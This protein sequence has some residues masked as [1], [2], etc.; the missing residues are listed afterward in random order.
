MTMSLDRD[1]RPASA[2]PTADDRAA[3]ADPPRVAN[4]RPYRRLAYH[5][6]ANPAG[7]MLILSMALH[8]VAA[9]AQTADPIKESA[10]TEELSLGETAPREKVAAS[11]EPIIKISGEIGLTNFDY[12]QYFHTP[13]DS[14]D[15]AIG[16]NLIA[17]TA[18][19]AGFSAGAGVYVGQTLGLQDRSSPSYNPELASPDGNRTSLRQAYV[20]YQ[21]G[22]LLVRAGRQLVQTP[23][24]TQDYFTFHPRAFSG[25]AARYD[26]LG[27]T[28]KGVEVGAMSLDTSPARL[29]VMAIRMYDFAGRFVDGFTSGSEVSGGRPTRGFAA[30]G[31]RYNG[32]IG[33]TKLVAQSWYYDFIDYARLAYGHVAV[34]APIATDREFVAAVQAFRQWN[35]SG[36]GR[37]LADA[38][39]GVVRSVDAQIYGASAGSRVGNV[40]VSAIGNYAPAAPGAFRNGGAL[41][42]YTMI[43]YTLFSDTL[44]TGVA[45]LGPGYGYGI[46][47]TLKAFKGKF[48][49]SLSAVR[50]KARY[51]FGKDV[52]T[53]RGPL[54]FG[55]LEATPNQHSWALDAI[56]I[57]DM[58]NIAKGLSSSY[59][60]G[61][62][63]TDNG[64]TLR[65]YDNPF[66][67]SRFYLKW[68]F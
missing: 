65:R 11:A 10:R 51:G 3:P 29:S 13:Q 60:L 43:P 37:S 39:D 50:Y 19:L 15:L 2:L 34:R 31:M 4:A 21:S 59:V 17:H 63:H 61:I 27:D 55:G 57:L 38:T 6:L 41:Q 16:G 42:P 40:T 9:A 45:E 30:L 35:S 64:T 47:V 44:Q 5:R 14:H 66:V 48:S 24:A 33:T 26:L 32:G 12:R 23:F 20:Q 68:A 67:I 25:F 1:R 18:S 56:N 22:R 8:P 58:S 36:N 53:Y 62:A 28:G 7:I 46:N 54:G 52:Y 49:S